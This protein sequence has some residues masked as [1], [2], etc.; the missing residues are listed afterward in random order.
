MTERQLKEALKAFLLEKDTVNEFE[1]WLGHTYGANTNKVKQL[2]F[3]GS[4]HFLVA[5]LILGLAFLTLITSG[6]LWYWHDG[7]WKLAAGAG[8][9][10][11]VMQGYITG[12]LHTKLHPKNNSMLNQ[13]VS[14]LQKLIMEQQSKMN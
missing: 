3:W 11:W 5:Y 1:S 14:H 13:G 2:G 4:F 12:V 6:V 7:L 9:I 10:V 8:L